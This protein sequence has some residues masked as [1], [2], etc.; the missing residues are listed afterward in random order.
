MDDGLTFPD[1]IT[2][3]PASMD[4]CEAVTAL[5]A[6]SELHDDGEVE[7]EI[8]DVRATWSRPTFDPAVDALLVLEDHEPVAWAEVHKGRRAEADVRPDRRGRGIGAAVLGWTERRA[9]E[10][11]GSVVGQT[12][13]DSNAGAAALFRQRGY[14]PLWTS[15]ALEISL[16]SEPAAATAPDGIRIRPYE[17]QSDDA[18]AYRLIEQAFSEWPDREP[19]S[20]E[21]WVATIPRH[22]AFVPDATRVALDGDRMVGASI[23][24]EY[25]NEGWVQQLAVERSHRNR[26]IARA[27]L[28]DVFRA[29][30]GRGSPK[31]GVGTDSRTGAS[32]LYESVGMHAR[33]SYTHWAREL[34]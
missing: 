17:P 1:G 32:S 11:G 23:S 16:A 29:F 33:R 10:A 25:G 31:C 27:L 3:R 26:G 22:G 7:I 34:D 4:D 8:E 6:A 21:D 19:T 28:Q 15:W 9:R 2:S 12:V 13:T 24:F 18:D 30:H 20:F 14:D 5:I